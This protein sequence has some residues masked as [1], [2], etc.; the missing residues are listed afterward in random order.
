MKKREQGEGQGG[1]SKRLHPA[2]SKAGRKANL[3][4]EK[5]RT[6]SIEIW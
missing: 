1:R 4:I 5:R 6:Y 2:V 3:G